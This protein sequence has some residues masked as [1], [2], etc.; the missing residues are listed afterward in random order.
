[1]LLLAAFTI[2]RRRK[3]I[4]DTLDFQ[5]EHMVVLYNKFGFGDEAR[6]ITN[7]LKEEVSYLIESDNLTN[8]ILRHKLDKIDDA[9]KLQEEMIT[10]INIHPISEDIIR[11]NLAELY[12]KKSDTVSARSK[13]T[14]LKRKEDPI[15]K[16]RLGTNETIKQMAETP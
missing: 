15:V 8:S 11:I 7:S 13:V 10:I 16:I 4:A 9:I 14:N 12:V 5:R 1:M 2:L 6:R 3:V